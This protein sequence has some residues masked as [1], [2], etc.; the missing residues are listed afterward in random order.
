MSDF[1]T[2]DIV[3]NGSIVARTDVKLSTI[4]EIRD[5]PKWT[6]VRTDYGASYF[7]TL[8]CGKMLRG[9]K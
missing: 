3:E 5:F 4:V 2:L 7:V 6:H 1:V 8:E 9:M